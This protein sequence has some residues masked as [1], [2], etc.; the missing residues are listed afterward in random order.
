MSETNET[1]QKTK[2]MNSTLIAAGVAFAVIFI[3]LG[4]L[5][6]T[7]ENYASKLIASLLDL[8]TG[9]DFKKVVEQVGGYDTSQTGIAT[10]L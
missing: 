7:K 8:I 6:M 2:K 4:F 9:E 10:F 5:V 1:N 3:I